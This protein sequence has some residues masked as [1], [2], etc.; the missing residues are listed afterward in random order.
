MPGAVQPDEQLEWERRAGRTAGLAAIAASIL[1]FAGALVFPSLAANER[2]DSAAE[3]LRSLHDSPADAI[4]P[5]VLQVLGYLALAYAL[6]YLYRATKARREELLG[7]TRYLVVIGPIATAIAFMGHQIVVLQAASD[8]VDE[9]IPERLGDAGGGLAAQAG[10]LLVAE[11]TA[12][13]LVQDNTGAPLLVALQYAGVLCVAFAFVL[14]GMNAMR[15]GLLSRFMGYLGIAIGVLTVL[16]V[17]GPI[18]VV[19][20]IFWLGALGLIY[21]DR[22]PSGRGPAWEEVEAIPWPSAMEQ[23]A[24]LERERAGEEYDED[25]EYYEE[26]EELIEEEEPEPTPH[27]VSKKRKKKKRRR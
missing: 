25:E 22:W 1:L 17:F 12:R 7:A 20:E 11:D 26:D 27:P 21:L 23:R 2:R 13:D 5:G 6:Y 3:V 19:I 14:L 15:A 18:G 16:A 24:A 9:R 10:L 8:F 4:A